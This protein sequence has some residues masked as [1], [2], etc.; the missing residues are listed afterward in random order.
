MITITYIW[1]GVSFIAVSVVA[2]V[3]QYYGELLALDWRKALTRKV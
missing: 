3:A 1:G 2:A